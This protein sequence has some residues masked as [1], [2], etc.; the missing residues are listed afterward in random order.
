MSGFDPNTALAMVTTPG[1]WLLKSCNG[2][3]F[4]VS[5]ISLEVHKANWE[6]KNVSFLENVLNETVFWV[7]GGKT[8]F[9]SAFEKSQY[10]SCA[11]MRE[12]PRVLRPGLGPHSLQSR[13]TQLGI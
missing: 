10:F 5:N 2:N 11:R 8:H 3:C 4:A 6:N 12:I 1:F 7:G 13:V 9:E